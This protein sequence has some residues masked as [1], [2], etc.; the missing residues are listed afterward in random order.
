[1]PNARGSCGAVASAA[2]ALLAVPTMSPIL[3]LCAGS[4]VHLIEYRLEGGALSPFPLLRCRNV[5]VLPGIPALLQVGW[6]WALGCAV[7][8]AVQRA[9]VQLMCPA[10]LCRRAY[11]WRAEQ[12]HRV[13]A[14][15]C[16][17]L[18]MFIIPTFHHGPSQAKWRAV[19]EHLLS[20][21]PP[22]APFRTALLRLR[23]SDETQVG[24]RVERYMACLF[25]QLREALPAC[26]AA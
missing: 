25:V 18:L 12:E 16:L 5:Y 21:A 15:G 1:M 4:E 14:A 8:A 20:E 13:S 3:C 19:E 24:R 10:C 6:L 22:S 2:T 9:T 11:H 23:L 7:H 17:R 26:T